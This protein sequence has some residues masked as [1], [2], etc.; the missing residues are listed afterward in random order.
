MAAL[1][2]FSVAY[3]PFCTAFKPVWART[4]ALIDAFR[5]P[6]QAR[7]IKCE[8]DRQIADRYGVTSFPTILLDDGRGHVYKYTGERKPQSVLNWVWTLAGVQTM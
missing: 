3:C 1:L 8:A 6:V 7:E 5:V 4:I 2:Y